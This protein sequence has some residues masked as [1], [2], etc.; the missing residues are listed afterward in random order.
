VCPYHLLKDLQSSECF[1]FQPAYA[2]T[3]FQAIS[4]REFHDHKLYH[5]FGPPLVPTVAHVRIRVSPGSYTK[6]RR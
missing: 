5:R 4:P 6:S 1:A 3:W 2:Q